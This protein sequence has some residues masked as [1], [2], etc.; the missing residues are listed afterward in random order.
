M[1]II[2]L[3]QDIRRK[4]QVL[5]TWWKMEYYITMLQMTVI[6]DGVKFQVPVIK[7]TK[8]ENEMEINISKDSLGS[9][10]EGAKVWFKALDASWNVMSTTTVE[11]IQKNLSDKIVI[12]DDMEINGYQISTTLGGMRTVYS[13]NDTS[14]GTGGIRGS[15][16]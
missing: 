12:S 6:G 9:I 13:L 14:R 3:T 16:I 5:N 4:M 2:I 15:L 7:V 11:E 10:S 1:P 8:T